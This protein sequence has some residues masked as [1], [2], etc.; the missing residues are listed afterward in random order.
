MIAERVEQS[1]ELAGAAAAC[2]ELAVFE[3]DIRGTTELGRRDPVPHDLAD[4]GDLIH[5]AE[6]TVVAGL[7]REPRAERGRRRARDELGR[8]CGQLL[9]ALGIDLSECIDAHDLVNDDAPIADRVDELA[10]DEVGECGF[11]V[12]VFGQRGDRGRCHSLAQDR[13]RFERGA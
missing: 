7:P 4:A 12:I 3:Q 2:R 10:R 8:R 1:F 13:E 11:G 6:R 9:L 5:R